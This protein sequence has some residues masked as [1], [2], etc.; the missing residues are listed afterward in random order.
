MK[1]T[2]LLVIVSLLILHATVPAAESF[3]VRSTTVV[4]VTVQK[5]DTQTI[6]IGYNDALSI[7]FPKPSPFLKGVE[8]EIKIPQALLPYRN[9]MAYGVYRSVVPAPVTG[10]IDYQAEQISMQPLPSRLSFVLQIPATKAHGLKTSPYATVLP[11]VHDPARGPL[12]FRLLPVMKGLPEGIETMGFVV[13]VKPLLSD[14]GALSLR[15]RQP[16]DASH[17]VSVRVDENLIPAP[18]GLIILPAGVH[19]L[20]IVSDD[21]RDEVRM[22]TVEPARVTALE[23]SMQGTTPT[24]LV[25]AP[26]NAKILLDGQPLSNTR[27]P[28]ELAPGDHTIQFTIGDYELTRKIQA[29]K[30]KTYTVSMLIDVTIEES[31]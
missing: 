12:F 13:R 8:I 5:P 21:Y 30:G 10:T 9:S 19:N 24:L 16:G 14:E 31:P 17:P 23:V 29:E 20:S 22:F 26:E 6:E 2:A 18:D 4:Q 3:R 11:Y 15:I 1:K 27:D 25:V 7:E 28:R